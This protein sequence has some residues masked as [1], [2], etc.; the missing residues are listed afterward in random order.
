MIYLKK[1][2]DVIPVII[3]IPIIMLIAMLIGFLSF[4]DWITGNDNNT[5]THS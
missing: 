3:A 1:C 2:I 4:Y 5:N